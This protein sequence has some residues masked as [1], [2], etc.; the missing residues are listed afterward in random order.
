MITRQDQDN[1]KKFNE[2]GKES[3]ARAK[4]EQGLSQERVFR[5]RSSKRG[6]GSTTID[7]VWW[8]HAF[9]FFVRHHN[10]NSPRH[11]NELDC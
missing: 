5:R 10:S 6:S 11:G 9:F 3:K 4:G 2:E 7:W 1:Q 8:M